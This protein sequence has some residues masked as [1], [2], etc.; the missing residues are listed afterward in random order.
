MKIYI[1]L[2]ISGHD[3]KQCKDRANYLA[4]MIRKYGNEAVTPFDIVPDSTKPYSYCMGRDIEGLLECDA[5]L[6][7]SGWSDSKGCQLEWRCAQI[8]NK[9]IFHYLNDIP[10]TKHY[11]SNRNRQ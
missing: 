9:E 6:L 5:I 1:S 10:K 11:E 2:P 8:Y 3:I 7:C 4:E